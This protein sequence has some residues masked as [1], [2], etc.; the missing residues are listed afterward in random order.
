MSVTLCT[1]MSQSLT[2][3]DLLALS[4]TLPAD[5]ARQY[6]IEILEGLEECHRHG[7]LHGNISCEH[8]FLTRST[9]ASPILADFGGEL[10]SWAPS[11][12]PARWQPPEAREQSSKTTL[13]KSDVWFL[14]VVVLQMC[15]GLDV[16]KYSSPQGA[17]AKSNVTESFADLLGKMFHLD[18]R[19]RSTA[20]DLLTAEFLRSNDTIIDQ[21]LSSGR[22]SDT[23]GAVDLPRRLRHESSNALEPMSRYAQDFVEIGRLGRGGFGEV[24]KA[25]N[26]LDGGVYAIKKIHHAP[27][28][29]RILSEVMLLN[30]LNHPYVVR[31]YATWVE[32]DLSSSERDMLSSTTDGT[33]SGEPQIDFGYQSTGGLDFV[34]SRGYNQ[35][36]FGSDSESD[37]ESDIFEVENGRNVPSDSQASIPPVRRRSQVVKAPSTLFIQMEFCERRSL[38]DL[39]HKGLQEDQA[40]RFVRQITEGLAHIHGH[41]IIHR[42]LKPDNIFIDLAGSPKIGDFGLATT[43]QYSSIERTHKFNSQVSM[44]MTMSIGTA[45]YVAPEISASSG[46]PYTDKVDMYSLGVMFYEMCQVFPTAME[47]VQALQSLRK[48]DQELPAPYQQSGNKAAQ[49]KVISCLVSHKAGERPSSAELLRAGLLPV[50]IED[51]TIRQALLSLTDRDSPN[52][53][54]MMSALFSTNRPAESQVRALAWDAKDPTVFDDAL[55]LRARA[56]IKDALV[57]IFRLHGAEELP[58]AGLLPRAN[59]YTSANVVQLL[60]ASGNLLQL[61]YDLTLPMARRLA[62]SDLHT[63]CTYTIDPVYR[64]TFSGGPPQSHQEIDFDIVT[65]SD[66]TMHSFHEAE[67]IKVVDEIVTEPTLALTQSSIAFYLNH[68]EILNLILNSAEIE[69]AQHLAVKDCLSKLGFRHFTWAK[70][71][72]ELRSPALALSSWSVDYLQTFD[73]REPPE[74]AFTTLQ[75]WSNNLG[76]HAKAKLQGAID[77]IRDVVD[78]ASR[79]S[80]TCRLLISPLSCINAKFYDNATMIQCVLERKSSRDVLAAG[81][82]YDGLIKAARMGSSVFKPQAAVGISVGLDR[83]VANLLR[84]ANSSSTGEAFTKDNAKLD[85]LAKRCNVLLLTGPTSTA[86]AAGTKVLATLWASGISAEQSFDEVGSDDQQYSFV[87]TY[88]HENA[89][90]IKVHD[91]SDIS[92]ESDVPLASIVSYL[93]QELREKQGI[94]R[95][96]QVL[97]RNPSQQT[98][99]RKNN[100]QVLMSGHRSKKSNKYHIVEAAQQK[101]AERLDQWKDAP[102]LAVETRDDV[103]DLMRETRFSDAETWRKALHG[104]PP[105]ERLYVQQIQELLQAWRRKWVDGEQGREA[106]LYNFRTGHSIYY[107]LAL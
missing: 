59:L 11:K 102:I 55:R 29:D 3:A 18:P 106:C 94:R 50:K 49:G 54:T 56:V 5:K 69:P 21:D 41:G 19:M 103:L 71:R 32:Q 79:M 65:T 12:L 92:N 62:R 66:K 25:R 8:I 40:W 4:F 9:P 22:T 33:L 1:E 101:W 61:P 35:I 70:V 2:L 27:Q 99:D 78:H 7:I 105:N 48:R 98:V 75:D 43:A 17:W 13:K 16:T 38:R 90:T 20:F 95:R 10:L 91:T 86:Q 15:L 83:L 60:D 80:V 30:R 37:E 46:V 72:S 77:H 82:R 93:H 85:L 36:E 58:R 14:G 84:Q 34:S 51:E 45:L 96:H 64:D 89:T 81:G 28:L 53:Q 39:L 57:S 104:V 31:Y 87:L 73:W 26:K 63:R 74:K 6:T 88:R 100:V 67:V 76:E 47:R 68:N 42:D 44:D 107:D 23:N 24:V 52:H 97:G